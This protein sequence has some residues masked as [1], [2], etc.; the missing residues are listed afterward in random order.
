MTEDEYMQLKQDMLRIT[1][2]K[3]KEENVENDGEPPED[4]KRD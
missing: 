1:V 4:K 2:M 3:V